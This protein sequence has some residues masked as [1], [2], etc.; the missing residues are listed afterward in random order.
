[1][2]IIFH[3]KLAEDYGRHHYIEATSIRDALEG[4]SRQLEIYSHLPLDKRPAFR[5]AGHLTVESLEEN[6]EQIHILPAMVGGGGLAKIAIGSLL[7]VAGI[8]IPGTQFLISVGVGMVLGGISEL[9]LKAPTLSS[10]DDPDA[11]KYLGLG[12]NTT[13]LGT[14]RL[15]AMGRVKITS[16]H[17]IAVN[18]DSNN[19]V[20]GEF[21]A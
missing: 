13:K 18:V 14:V 17:V 1:M 21:P 11:S 4:L 9:F 10:E 5:V 2:Q 12:N 16:P 15:Y 7:I 3:G 8:F 6:P 20:K 19:L